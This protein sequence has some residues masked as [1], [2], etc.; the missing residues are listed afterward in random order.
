LCEIA[1][2]Q[3]LFNGRSFKKKLYKNNCL[4]NKCTS[5]C[6]SGEVFCNLKCQQIIMFNFLNFFMYKIYVYLRINFSHPLYIYIYIYIYI[7]LRPLSHKPPRGADKG[8]EGRTDDVSLFHILATLPCHY[9]R[10]V[11]TLYLGQKQFCRT[12]LN[13]LRPYNIH[14]YTYYYTIRTTTFFYNSVRDPPT[15]VVYLY[16]GSRLT[17]QCIIYMWGIAWA[18]VNNSGGGG[19]LPRCTVA[20]RYKSRVRKEEKT[21]HYVCCSF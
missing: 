9:S 8:G 15:V 11:C 13:A 12:P 2:A 7:C 10:G 19:V 3:F 5:K 21:K 17:A 4:T 16:Q 1:N 6:K 20:L 18:W 14:V